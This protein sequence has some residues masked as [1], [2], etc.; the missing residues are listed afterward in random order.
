M[1]RNWTFEL[2]TTL[3]ADGTNSSLFVDDTADYLLTGDYPI[4]ALE[5]AFTDTTDRRVAVNVAA[6][7][8]YPTDLSALTDGT[9]TSLPSPADPNGAGTSAPGTGECGLGCVIF[10]SGDCCDDD[11]EPTSRHFVGNMASWATARVAQT[12]QS[13]PITIDAN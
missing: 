5:V 10:C 2:K 13:Q 9:I 3:S 8:T 6:N 4:D 11:G 7:G 12:Q 1:A